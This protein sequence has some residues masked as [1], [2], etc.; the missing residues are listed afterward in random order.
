MTEAY[1]CRLR[2]KLY[3]L[4]YKSNEETHIRVITP[5]GVTRE[6]SR[7]EGLG[8]GSV[9]VAMLSARSVDGGVDSMFSDS[10]HEVWYG[11]GEAA[12]YVLPGRRH[13]RL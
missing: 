2:G 5:V 11:E 9:D 10:E 13:A 1:N 6:S 3:Q 12:A 7:G 4:I 8:Q